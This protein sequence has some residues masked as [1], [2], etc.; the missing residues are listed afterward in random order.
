MG[1]VSGSY[2]TPERK[3]VLE[4]QGKTKS[5]AEASKDYT[6]DADG[7]GPVAKVLK[8]QEP[9]YIQDVSTC[10][11][12]KRGNVAKDY[13]IE[14]I[15]FVAVPGGVLEYG[16]SVGPCT[17]H[18]TCMEDARK[19]IMPKEELQKAFDWGATHVI[20]WHKEGDEYSVG[21]SYVIPEREAA[22][23]QVRGDDKTYTSESHSFKLSADGKGPVAT[24]ARS[25]V[26]VILEDPTKDS[27]FQRQELA[28][29][30]NVGQCHFVPCKDGVLEYGTGQI[31]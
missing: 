29:E 21:A 11:V 19:A 25:G 27:T 14:S 31:E 20:F 13:G 22:L 18:W 24:A 8:T 10:D 5:F 30:F 6:L 9:F 7:D 17:A 12:M 26:T 3:A 2:V 15:C 16:A 23:R 28:K 1:A 4:A